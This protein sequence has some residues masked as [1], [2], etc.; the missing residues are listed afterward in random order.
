MNMN[1]LEHIK[2]T[3]V[4][5]NDLTSDCWLLQFE[6]FE[7]CAKCKLFPFN[8]KSKKLRKTSECGGGE[9]LAL[10]IKNHL[11]QGMS[12][13]DQH[14]AHEYFSQNKHGSFA[15]FVKT[16]REK[17]GRHAWQYPL[18][19]YKRHINYL[20]Q[21]L[22][23]KSEHK[24]IPLDTH[25]PYMQVLHQYIEAKQ[26]NRKY[27][28]RLFRKSSHYFNQHTTCDCQPVPDARS[29]YNIAYRD[30]A[31]QISEHVTVYYYHQHAIVA[32]DTL[33]K[34][35]AITLDSCGWRTSTTKERIN[36][37]IGKYGYYVYQSKYVWYISSREIEIKTEFYDGIT[38]KLE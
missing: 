15:D 19:K 26:N 1:A 16:I 28:K 29:K 35:R 10:M 14:N 38:L 6:G 4:K 33:N 20:K 24:T 17:Y 2:V 12:I 23:E 5:Q 13:M 34:A 30:E 37:Y 7:A 32:I 21:I 31:Y 11:A 25:F 9:T 36:G 27:P 3:T 22:T 8:P 18:N